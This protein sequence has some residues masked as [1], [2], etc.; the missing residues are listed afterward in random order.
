MTITRVI[1]RQVSDRR[2]QERRQGERR[3]QWLGPPYGYERRHNADFRV[4]PR[5]LGQDRRCAQG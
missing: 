3:V 2:T 4:G 1:V 5:R